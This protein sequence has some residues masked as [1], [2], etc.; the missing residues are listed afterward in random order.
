MKKVFPVLLLGV[1]SMFFAEVFSG[2]SQAWFFS[3]WGLFITFPLYLAHTV[4]LF[5]I[6]FRTKRT[7]LAQLYLFGVIFALYESWITK[8][9]WVGYFNSQGPGFGTFLGLGV[10]EFPVLVFFWHPIMSFILPILVFQILTKKS[11]VSHKFIFRKS[12]TRSV[13]IVLFLILVSTFIVQGNKASMFSVS[14]SLLGSILIVFL[15]YLLSRFASLNDININKK[16]FIGIGV[17]LCL[18]YLVTFFFLLPERIP[19]KLLPYLSILFFYVL[20]VSVLIFSK[21]SKEKFVK[22]SNK[23]YTIK[24]LIVFGI[25]VMIAANLFCLIPKISG[26][27]LILTYFLLVLIGLFLFVYSLCKIISKKV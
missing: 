24:D 17:Y 12:K 25:V 15:L 7:S 10:L 8:V 14:L 26:I 20:A 4:F 5:W 3:I 6:A 1:L 13:L 21:P 27:V 9:L 22:L 18:L 19:H 11:V 23:E 16:W 2:A